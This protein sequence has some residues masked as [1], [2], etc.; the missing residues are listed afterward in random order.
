MPEIL[1]A[2]EARAMAWAMAEANDN[3]SDAALLLGIPRQTFNYRYRKLTRA[4]ATG[5]RQIKDAAQRKNRKPPAGK[6]DA[7]DEAGKA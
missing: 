6:P 7:A 4:R 1:A 5:N 3:Q 2:E